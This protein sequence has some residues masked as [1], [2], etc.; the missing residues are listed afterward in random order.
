[1][2]GGFHKRGEL[3]DVE[4]F[5]AEIEFADLVL[6]VVLVH[7]VFDDGIDLFEDVRH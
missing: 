5:L 1:M 2:D 7:S 4:L 6:A 3:P